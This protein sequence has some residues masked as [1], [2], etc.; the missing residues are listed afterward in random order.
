MRP[1]LLRRI[2]DLV[3]AGATVLGP[4][5]S[6]S[7]SLEHYPRCDA[8]VR[9][10]AAELWGTS[11]TSTPGER[12]VGNGRVIWARSLAEVLA[13][14]ELPPDFESSVALRFTHR[15][16]TNAD[17][18]FVAN[19]G[20]EPLS[21][22]AAFRAGARAPEFWWPDSGRIERPAV[23]DVADGIVRVPLSLGPHGSVFVVFRHPADPSSERIVSVKR[24]GHEVLGTSVIS[25][26]SDVA[27]DHPNSFRQIPHAHSDAGVVEQTRARPRPDHGVDDPGIRFTRSGGE[28]VVAA[29]TPGD[30]SVTFGDGGVCQVR[31]ETVPAVQPLGGPWDVRFTPDQGA[32]EQ[33]VFD[34]LVDWTQHPDPGIRHCSGQATYRTTFELPAG[35]LGPVNIRTVLR[36]GLSELYGDV[37]IP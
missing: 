8:Q 37:T 36:R 12:R 27:M 11:N 22:T 6:R 5:P 29:S 2:R 3:K 7:P 9:K 14:L 1:D 21:T 35:L 30:Y 32:P 24:K 28:W 15:R 10:L 25:S 26:P 19:P 33:I 34:P 31:V 13:S 17:Y 23:Y 4:P 18:Y 16:G 20:A